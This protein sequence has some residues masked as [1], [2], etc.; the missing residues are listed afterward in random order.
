M[1][2]YLIKLLRI[3][4][5]LFETLI[6]ISRIAIKNILLEYAG[7]LRGYSLSSKWEK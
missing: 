7:L 4:K 6:R 5:F 3:G 2:D 1:Y